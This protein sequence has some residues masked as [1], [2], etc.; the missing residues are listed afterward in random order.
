M[1]KTLT[2]FT[3][4]VVALISMMGSV[5]ATS[6]VSCKMASEGTIQAGETNDVWVD[7][8]NEEGTT[9]SF[10]MVYNT[11]LFELDEEATRA[12]TNITTINTNYGGLGHLYMETTDISVCL[13]FKAKKDIPYEGNGEDPMDFEFK[14]VCIWMDGKIINPDKS[15]ATW[16][17]YPKT[18]P[19]QS[20]PEQPTS[21]QPTS[22]ESNKK[23]SKKDALDDEPNAGVNTAVEI[24]VS[25]LAIISLAVAVIAKK[26]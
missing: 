6:S 10:E 2:I 4:L 22:K 20:N 3:I 19:Q 17:L 11:D 1:K 8:L 15:S 25:G 14:A 7:V 26:H 13:V 16:S 18:T 21:E 24:F 23:S 5:N 12:G 9:L